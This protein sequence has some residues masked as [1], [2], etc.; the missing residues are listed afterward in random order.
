MTASL[1]AYHNNSVVWMVSTSALISNSSRPFT[2]PLVIVP[3]TPN[4]IG[5][6][7]TFMLY[8][9]SVPLQGSVTY[10]SF[11]FL[12]ILLFDLQGR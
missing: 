6:A 11:R 10:L 12:S 2:D 7:V 4:R 9:F 5:I 8:S 3:S 1:L